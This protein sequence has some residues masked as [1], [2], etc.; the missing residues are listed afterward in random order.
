MVPSAARKKYI[1]LKWCKEADT[2][3]RVVLI[4]RGASVF[5]TLINTYVENLMCQK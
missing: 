2:V 1:A 4:C 3:E 5:H